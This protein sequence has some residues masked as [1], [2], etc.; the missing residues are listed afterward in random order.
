MNLSV[1]VNS[2]DSQSLSGQQSLNNTAATAPSSPHTASMAASASQRQN[3]TP[4]TQHN[5]TLNTGFAPVLAYAFS[6]PFT[7]FS[8]K[9]FPGVIESTGLSRTFAAQGIKIPI[10]KDNEQK[11]GNGK[12]P[13]RDG[14][15]EDEEDDLE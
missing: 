13:R 5:T 15:V 11:N 4:A 9:R 2:P 10:R 1:D 7:V 12:R 14:E 6:E 8:A 3:H